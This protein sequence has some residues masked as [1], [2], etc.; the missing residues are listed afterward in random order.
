MKRLVIIALSV[1]VLY[2]CK[3]KSSQIIGIVSENNSTG[4]QHYFYCDSVTVI[5][6]SEVI[7]YVDGMPVTILGDAVSVFTP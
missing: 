4:S 1:L 6:K 7:A 3:F 2:S 5:S